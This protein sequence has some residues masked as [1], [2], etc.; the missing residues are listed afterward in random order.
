MEGIIT[1]CREHLNKM[2]DPNPLEETK[3]TWGKQ[4][5]DYIVDKN[6]VELLNDIR[7]YKKLNYEELS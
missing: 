1:K 7:N 4:I 2:G 5:K 6:R 3:G